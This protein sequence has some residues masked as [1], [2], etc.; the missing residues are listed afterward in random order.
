MSDLDNA[1]MKL[2]AA[3]ATSSSSSSS[4]STASNIVPAWKAGLARR[5]DNAPRLELRK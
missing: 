3:I 1:V 5:G 2:K 4:S